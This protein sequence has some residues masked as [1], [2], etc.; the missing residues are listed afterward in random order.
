MIRVFNQ[1]ISP[2]SIVL[3]LLE[4]WLITLA[5]LCGVWIR[6]WYN[7]ADIATYMALPYFSVQAVFFVLPLQ[8]CSY[9]FD[10]Y[11]LGAIHSRP[12]LMISVGQSVGAGS[13]LLGIA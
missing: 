4:W 11:T 3:L 7:T 10:L 6:F 2:K 9:Y 1:Y 8:L 5:L 12:D 13:L